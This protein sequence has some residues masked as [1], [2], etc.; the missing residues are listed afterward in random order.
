MTAE[1]RR[2]S[3]YQ[4]LN[5]ALKAADPTESV[6]RYL[7]VK[8][9][10]IDIGGNHFNLESLSKVIVVGAGKASVQM[11]RTVEDLLAERI[12]SGA[13]NTKYGHSEQLERIHVQECGHPVPDQ[14]GVEGTE[15]IL[16]LVSGSDE[17]TLVLCLISGGGS[18]LTPAPV[19]GLTLSEKQE[20]TRQLL[21]CGATINELN[22]VRKHLSKIKGG[23][24]V[25]SAFP[26]KV[27]SL[28]LSDVIG[29]P[30]DV[31]ASGPTVPDTTTFGDCLGILRQYELMDQLP[32]SVVNHLKAG[33]EGKIP[34]TPKPGD[35]IFNNCHN[36]VVGNNRIALE[37]AKA[38]AEEL[39]YRTLIMSTQLEGEAR[40]VGIVIAAVGKE[41]DL[42]GN[43]ISPPA[44][45]IW[46]GE[47]TVTVRGK[48][49]G[50][51][52]QEMALAFA[53]ASA[54][55]QGITMLSAGT[56]GTDGPTD[57][58]GAIVD[59]NTVSRAL[60]LG[61]SPNEYLRH[62]DSYNFFKSL[63]DLV[64]TGPTGTNVMDIQIVIV[65]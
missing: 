59:G 57:A 36:I 51:R 25:Y 56:D 5:A 65:G 63:G 58:A 24:L 17:N 23:R 30:L 32:L 42:S 40:E 9:N 55:K 20:V 46:G 26:A 62:N 50:G 49:T 31:I 11:A 27:V 47:T 35:P 34:E 15:K 29:D 18:A 10:F 61:L 3:A 60:S 2:N 38:K 7:R 6:K 37:A 64:I 53:I 48:G 13:I 33:A 41:A 43:P 52:N 54:G 1:D 39:G 44:C 45:L 28:I 19:G 22:T 12:S 4:I 14:N 21:R 16:Q 8:G